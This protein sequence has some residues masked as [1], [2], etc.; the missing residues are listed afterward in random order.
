MKVAAS[1]GRDD[2]ALVYIVELGSGRLV[3]C[4]ESVQPPLP[5]REKWVLLVSTMAGW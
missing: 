5:R 3:E 2:I 4:V 1:T